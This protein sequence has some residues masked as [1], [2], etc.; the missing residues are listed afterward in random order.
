LVGLGL[1]S[2]GWFVGGLEAGLKVTLRALKLNHKFRR[3][4]KMRKVKIA[5]RY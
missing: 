1:G 4:P 3:N 2:V 5:Q